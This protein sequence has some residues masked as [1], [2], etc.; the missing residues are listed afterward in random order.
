MFNNFFKL[1]IRNLVRHKGFTFIN[2]FGL[3]LGCSA[4]MLICL[5]VWDEKKFDQ[6]IPGKESIYRLYVNRITETANENV[7]MVPPIFAPTLKQ[8]FPEVESVTRV[9]RLYDKQLLEYGDKQVYQ[10]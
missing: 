9:F 4:F 2:I 7:A 6:H 8:Q 3:T 10:D 1:A 5:F